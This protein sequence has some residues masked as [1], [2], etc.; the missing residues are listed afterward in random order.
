MGSQ[1][2]CSATRAWRCASCGNGWMRQGV[3]RLAGK[4]WAGRLSVSRVEVSI[5]GGSTW[6]ETQLGEAMW[7]H[8]WR[9][10]TYVWNANPGSHVLCVR[11]SAADG[12]MQ[13]I[14]QQ[15]NFGGYGNNGVQRV[16]VV[17]R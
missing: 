3:E 10:W 2:H 8:A 9:S 5:D 13:P 11:A 4:A 14:D 1:C 6:S 15:W 17:V 12:N 7:Q 16:P